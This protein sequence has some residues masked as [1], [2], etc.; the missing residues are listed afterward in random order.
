MFDLIQVNIDVIDRNVQCSRL[1]IVD[2]ELLFTW[3]N[4]RRNMV[5]RVTWYDIINCEKEIE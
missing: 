1:S 5:R 3:K 2:F 4:R